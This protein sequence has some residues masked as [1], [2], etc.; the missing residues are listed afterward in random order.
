MIK[1]A[2]KVTK[3]C[4]IFKVLFLPFYDMSLAASLDVEIYIYIYFRKCDF[5][6]RNHNISEGGQQSTYFITNI[7]RLYLEPYINCSVNSN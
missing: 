2:N 3:H 5:I 7:N 4:Y 1:A 6:T